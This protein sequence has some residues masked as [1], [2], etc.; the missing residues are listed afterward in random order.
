[1]LPA[2]SFGDWFRR[3][4]SGGGSAESAEDAAALHE[5]YGGAFDPGASDNVVAGGVGG[6]A[7]LES[8]E[9]AQAE[10]EELEAP[11]DPAP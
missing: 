1:M 7:G 3:L 4:F 10:E 6:L 11:P 2:V 5:E 9:A 8:A